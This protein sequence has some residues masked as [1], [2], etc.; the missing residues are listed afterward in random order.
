MKTYGYKRGQDNYIEPWQNPKNFLKTKKVERQ[1]AKKEIEEEI[2]NDIK[3]H[4]LKK[5]SNATST[6]S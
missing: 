3:Y 5:S 6:S 4:L 2:E 1:Q